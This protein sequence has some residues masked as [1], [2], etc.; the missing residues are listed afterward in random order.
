MRF[1]L[2]RG[3]ERH[4][5]E[6]VPKLR[7]FLQVMKD[8][9][10]P[11]QIGHL[12]LPESFLALAPM[13]DI[14]D[15]PFRKICKPFG[16]DLMFTEFVASE[17]LIRGIEKSQKKLV[18]TKSERPIGIQLFGNHPERLGEAAQLVAEMKPD[19]IDL[20]FGCPVS[21]IVSKGNGAAMLKTPDLMLEITRRVCCSVKIPVT[22]KTRLGWDER[23]KHIVTLAEQL[24]DCGIA[25]LTIHGRTKT[26]MYSG[27]ADWT[28]IGEVKNNPRMH[29]PIIGNGDITSP[30]VAKDL[31]DRYGV[32]G[33][34]I[35]RAAIGNPWIFRDIK[36][37]FKTGNILM[38]PSVSE[39]VNLC[40]K[41]L[42]TAVQWKGE[43]RAVL[44][45]RKHYSGYFKGIPDFKPFRVRLLESTDL[46]SSLT[47]LREVMEGLGTRD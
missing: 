32:D 16:V 6:F 15:P 35:G 33:L 36:H 11:V 41:H 26:Q 29:I 30:F 4:T 10:E 34:M 7:L 31:L 47:A 23:S 40:K 42:Q 12:R 17:G 44:E 43:K 20:N 45:M 18:Y 22:V 1:I 25:A 39:R 2:K 3:L 19:L 5:N 13:E 24:Q 9:S 14:T 28:L 21:K 8:K 38:P 37:F 46:E 27:K